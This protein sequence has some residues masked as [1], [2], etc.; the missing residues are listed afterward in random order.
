MPGITYIVRDI[1]TIPWRP[2]VVGFEFSGKVKPVIDGVVIW[3]S[4]KD[5]VLTRY[6]GTFGNFLFSRSMFG[7]LVF[8]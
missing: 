8:E 7:C 6:A 3:E 1:G 5:V 2:A 4:D